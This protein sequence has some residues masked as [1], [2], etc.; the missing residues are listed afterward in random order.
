MQLGADA[1]GQP[2]TA[3][4]AAVGTWIQFRG[5]AVIQGI[6]AFATFCAASGFESAE[7]AV[8]YY[9]AFNLYLLTPAMLLVYLILYFRK[10]QRAAKRARVLK[11]ASLMLLFCLLLTGCT[12]REL[13]DRIFPMALELQL[14]GEEIVMTYAWN[15]SGKAENKDEENKSGTDSAEPKNQGN[16]TV[17]RGFGLSDIW[18]QVEEYSDRYID[19]S[20][21]K[22]LIL[23]EKISGN[24]KLEQEFYEW[25]AGE[26]AFAAS[27]IIY[28]RE[29]SGITLEDAEQ[30]SEG[31]IGTYFENLYQNNQKYRETAATLGEVTR[32]YYAGDSGAVQ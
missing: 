4:P 2:E 12:A 10:K 1:P 5:L 17:F 30:R 11:A 32:A 27:L 26:P 19:Y 22:A 31:E 6:A 14:E 16:L 24:P 9:R 23:D 15:G 7:I 28:P 29:K 8:C 13:E 25:L 21:V 18:Q 20:H 3:G